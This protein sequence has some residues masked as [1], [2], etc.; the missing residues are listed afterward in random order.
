[1]N[2]DLLLLIIVTLICGCGGG[3][4][5][6]LIERVKMIGN[7][8]ILVVSELE[9]QLYLRS[10]LVLGVVAAFAIPAFLE[11][12]SIGQ[13]STTLVDGMLVKGELQSKSILV[14]SGFCLIAAVSGQSFV[15]KLSSKI[16]EQLDA[17]VESAQKNINEAMRR[18]DEAEEEIEELMQDMEELHSSRGIPTLD[19]Q[20][21][22][23]LREIEQSDHRRVDIEEMRS[24]TGFNEEQIRSSLKELEEFYM[25]SEKNTD[26]VTTW[27]TRPAGRAA[28]KSELK[29]E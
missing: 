28:L 9:N 22:R 6:Y 13:N 10:S 8:Q 20:V 14:Y 15:T 4:G 23:V 16:I 3:Y 27:R 18:N 1:M 26:G 17:Q 12:A 2:F 29:Q 5:G 7:S 19:P 21:M 11:L 24:K 25:L